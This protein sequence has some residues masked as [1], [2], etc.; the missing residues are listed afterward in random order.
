MFYCC[1]WACKDVLSGDNLN[2]IYVGKVKQTQKTL[3][4]AAAKKAKNKH[5]FGVYKT[6]NTTILHINNIKVC[7]TS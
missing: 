3:S 7:P 2:V 1:I 4:P 6:K 5:H